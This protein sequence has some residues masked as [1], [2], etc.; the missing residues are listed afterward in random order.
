MK[1]VILAT[2]LGTRFNDEFDGRPKPLVQ[3]LDK[4]LIA[5]TLEALEKADVVEEVLVVTGYRGEEVRAAV[6]SWYTGKVSFVSNPRFHEGLSYSLAAAQSFC[7]DDPFLLLMSDHVFSVELLKLLQS[8][9][10]LLSSSKEVSFIAADASSR[11]EDYVQEATKLIVDSDNLVSRIGKDLN[12]SKILD[13]GA[14]YCTS[15]IWK[16]L[17]SAPENCSLSRV[18]EELCVKQLLCSVDVTGCFWYDIDTPDDL[19][20]AEVSLLQVIPRD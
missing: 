6:K 1:A 7:A 3:L 16:A 5:Y 11:P 10:A 4:P 20:N 12:E 13:T 15:A 9:A 14:F 17:E 2:G 18:I 19:K 8:K